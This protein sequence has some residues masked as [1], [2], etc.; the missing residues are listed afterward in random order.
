MQDRAKFLKILGFHSLV[1]Y[2]VATVHAC[3][4]E[5][6][7]FEYAV[8]GKQIVY[9]DVHANPLKQ[10][11][12]L[13]HLNVEK[14]H[15]VLTN[16]NKAKPWL[17]GNSFSKPAYFTDEAVVVWQGKIV[18]NPLSVHPVDAATFKQLFDYSSFAFDA[19]SLYVNGQWV[20][21][22]PQLDSGKLVQLDTYFFS[23]GRY[24][25]NRHRGEVVG[26]AAG[27]RL[28]KRLE[29]NPWSCSMNDN[30]IVAT[31]D[32]VYVNGMPLNVDPEHFKVVRWLAKSGTLYYRDQFG[33]HVVTVTTV[34]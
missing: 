33:Q 3:L 8:S 15:S 28:L 31:A 16:V 2:Q 23:D 10:I 11:Q 5:M 14:F 20:G 26:K 32:N 22:N 1:L 25:I 34:D 27:Y 12:R 24:L 6:P 29:A 9:L 21:H 4:P 7:P 13:S 17:D 18:E 30:V 19:Y